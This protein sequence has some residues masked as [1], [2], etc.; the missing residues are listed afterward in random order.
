MKL[1]DVNILIYAHREDQE[2]HDFY[3]KKLETLCREGHFFGLTPSV[4][5]GFVR[6]CTHPKFPNGPTPQ[7][8]ALA[9]VESLMILPQTDWVCPGRAQWE[10]FSHLCRKT[11]CRGKLVADAHHAATAIEH[12][13]VWVSR[14]SDFHRF[15][16]HGLRF[17]SWTPGAQKLPVAIRS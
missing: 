10:L 7:P 1:L 17:E 11:A 4:A 13:C 16:P 12:T 2:H 8:M 6:V 14:D 9:F 3:R 15:V 5:S